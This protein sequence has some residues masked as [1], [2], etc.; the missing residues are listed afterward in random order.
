M[1]KAD[2]SGILNLFRVVKIIVRVILL[3]D[4]TVV[5]VI[6]A[7]TALTAF[8][9]ADE[10]CR[11]RSDDHNPVSTLNIQNTIMCGVIVGLPRTIGQ[12]VVSWM[13]YHVTVSI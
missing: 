2:T 4:G 11:T 3:Q 5:Y 7:F 12:F 13:C 9:A 8:S 10:C 6:T 1:I